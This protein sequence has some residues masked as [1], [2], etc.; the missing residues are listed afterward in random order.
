MFLSTAYTFIRTVTIA[1][2]NLFRDA[3]FFSVNITKFFREYKMK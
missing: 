2:I 1:T 3:F